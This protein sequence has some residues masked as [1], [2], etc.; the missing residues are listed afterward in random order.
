MK[1][2]ESLSLTYF[3]KEEL[4]NNMEQRTI[5]LLNNLEGKKWGFESSFTKLSK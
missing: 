3:G 1:D 2:G 5:A 4:P